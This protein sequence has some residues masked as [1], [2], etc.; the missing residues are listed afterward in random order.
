MVR[1][2]TRGKKN[3]EKLMSTR[4]KVF[5][6]IKHIHR[7][8]YLYLSNI[9]NVALYQIKDYKFNCH[10]DIKLSRKWKNSCDN[11]IS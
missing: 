11:L 5:R 4:W 3:I 2:L 6:I 7:G 9:D 1:K 8:F 10:P